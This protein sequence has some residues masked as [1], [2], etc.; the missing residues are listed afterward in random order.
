M[1]GQKPKV[2]GFILRSVRGHCS[3]FVCGIRL[4]CRLNPVE[5]FWLVSF[6]PPNGESRTLRPSLLR[7]DAPRLITLQLLDRRDPFTC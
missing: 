2:R 4:T 1:E 7:H 6:H 5:P 3:A